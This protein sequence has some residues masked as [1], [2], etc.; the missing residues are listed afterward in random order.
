VRIAAEPYW[1]GGIYSNTP[2]EVVLNDHPR[3]DATIFAVQLWNPIGAEPT[4][5]WQINERQKDIQF[6]SRALSHIANQKKV[7]KLRHIIRELSQ[8]MPAKL[9][10]TPD[11]KE[12]AARG[13]GTTM[14][15]V[16]MVAPRIEGE[17]HTKDIDFTGQ[18]IRARWQ[19]GCEDT[20]RAIAE[21]PW[22]HLVDSQD[23]VVI[24]DFETKI[25]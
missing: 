5:L 11:I 12:L 3:R 17:D 7:H 1:D 16:R 6:S 10:N 8:H 9:R 2:V 13:C 15:V 4:S 25:A 24:H 18:G 19:T 14:H 21:A 23:G 22:Q 20:H